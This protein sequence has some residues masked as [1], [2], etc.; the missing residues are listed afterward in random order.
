MFSVTKKNYDS[1]EILYDILKKPIFWLAL[2][3]FS[4]GLDELIQLNRSDEKFSFKHK[5][6]KYLK[7]NWNYFDIFG[8]LLF[9]IAMTLKFLSE[10]LINE[11]LFI[12]SR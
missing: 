12:A 4:F 1:N 11:S 7:N 10:T 3:I 9:F 6:N 2:W 8:F 5:L